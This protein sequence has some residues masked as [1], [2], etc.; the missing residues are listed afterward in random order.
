MSGHLDQYVINLNSLGLLKDYDLVSALIL[1]SQENR[2]ENLLDALR[3]AKFIPD[4]V[5]QIYRTESTEYIPTEL[6]GQGGMGC[7]Y[8]AYSTI[9]LDVT[10]AIRQMP[11]IVKAIRPDRRY[12]YDAASRMRREILISQLLTALPNPYFPALLDHHLAITSGFPFAVFDYVP[13][14]SLAA[15]LSVSGALPAYRAVRIAMKLVSAIY[16]L[17]SYGIV[18][19]D[20]KLSNVLIS[21]SEQVKLI[22]FGLASL[23]DSVVL[24]HPELAK[25]L[26]ET[27]PG[28]AFGTPNASAPEQ[29]FDPDVPPT[30]D[31]YSL[32]IILTSLLTGRTRPNRRTIAH[33]SGELNKLLLDMTSD[34]PSDRPQ[35][36]RDVAVRLAQTTEAQQFNLSNIYL[37][38][39]LR[40]AIDL[41]GFM[42]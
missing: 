21:D 16:D 40:Q 15:N 18:H 35:S 7:V 41:E 37:D 39:I 31:I 34:L 32:G 26:H 33:A 17:H 1:A 29:F 13:A 10:G 30:A 12:T 2:R 11:R 28:I 14:K 38:R 27:E 8:L 3:D 25:L 9:E 42:P 5:G 36:A 19:R 4:G 22:D 23:S 24:S 6:I 20:I